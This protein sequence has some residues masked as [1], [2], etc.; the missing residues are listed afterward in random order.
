[1]R[2][3]FPAEVAFLQADWYGTR[4]GGEAG[5]EMARLPNIGL[6]VAGLAVFALALLALVQGEDVTLTDPGTAPPETTVAD[7]DGTADDVQ[8][9]PEDPE[10]IV[11]AHPDKVVIQGEK[12]GLREV[13]Y[14]QVPLTV[15]LN[16]LDDEEKATSEGKAASEEKAA[17]ERK[18]ADSPP[19]LGLSWSPVSAGD[20]S[21]PLKVEDAKGLG[22]QQQGPCKEPRSTNADD[23]HCYLVELEGSPDLPAGTYGA[24]A[25]GIEVT[26][27]GSLRRPGDFVHFAHQGL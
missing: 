8:E 13:A 7:A 17:S 9:T 27:E 19:E 24:S 21:V 16:D 10:S 2:Q 20:G 6:G 12:W 5:E 18:A 4:K 26:L 25:V 11:R 1:M 14:E 22:S 23:P 15:W 3:R